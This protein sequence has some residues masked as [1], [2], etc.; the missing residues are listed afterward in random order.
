MTIRFC[1]L[2]SGIKLVNLGNKVYAEPLQAPEG[3][4]HSEWTRVHYPGYQLT[5]QEPMAHLW[6]SLPT[7][8]AGTTAVADGAATELVSTD[9]TAE[10]HAAE[11]VRRDRNIREGREPEDDGTPAAP[12][13]DDVAAVAAKLVEDAKAVAA[14]SKPTAAK[15]GA[16]K[17]NKR[18]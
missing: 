18:R 13:E 1:K 4:E 7:A 15:K 6:P 5:I 16:K 9:K 10:E 8:P 12:A 17:P 11:A 2:A 14:A 3:S